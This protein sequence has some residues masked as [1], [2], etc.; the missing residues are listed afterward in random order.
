MPPLFF[1]YMANSSFVGQQAYE[2]R[3]RNG[4]GVSPADKEQDTEG[5]LLATAAA[6]PKENG[7][8]LEVVKKAE[9]SDKREQADEKPDLGTLWGLLVLGLAYVHHSTSG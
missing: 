4:N 5:A 3:S 9:K 1:D 8:A 7:A 6:Q 2:A